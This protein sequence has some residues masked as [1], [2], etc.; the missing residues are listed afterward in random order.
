MAALKIFAPE[1]NESL[2]TRHQSPS[3]STL[4]SFRTIVS[5]TLSLEQRLSSNP[6][7]TRRDDES[8][9]SL[10]QQLKKN[11]IETLEASLKSHECVSTALQKA[12]QV[13]CYVG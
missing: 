2:P 11:D 1:E 6:L 10:S 7:L 4:S 8:S 9:S 3:M 13:L 12:I 5:Q